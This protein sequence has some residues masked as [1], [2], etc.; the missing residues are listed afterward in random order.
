MRATLLVVVACLPAP[1][2]AQYSPTGTKVL[3]SDGKNTFYTNSPKGSVWIPNNVDPK[4]SGAR[5]YYSL[6]GGPWTF[7]ATADRARGGFEFK[8]PKEGTYN[9]AAMTVFPK[10]KTD[11]PDTSG[12]E[13]QKT[14]VYDI[15]PPTFRYV[16]T[17]ATPDG[18]PGV[19]WEATDEYLDPYKVYLEYKW[20]TMS[21]FEPIDRDKRLSPRDA[22]YWE[23]RPGERMQVHVVAYDKAG[24]MAVSDP[25]W[26]GT[27]GGSARS[28]VPLKGGIDREGR[29]PRMPDLDPAGDWPGGGSGRPAASTAVLQYI[30]DTTVKLEYRVTVG[31]AG[32]GSSKLY[33]AGDDAL[34]WKLVPEAKAVPTKP[35]VAPATL[36]KTAVE[37][38]AF[39]Y[40]VP[41]EGKYSFLIVAENA[42]GTSQPEPK[43]GDAPHATLV[44][45]ITKPAVKI[46]KTAVRSNGDRGAVLDVFWDVKDVNLPPDGIDVEYA[47][48][49]EG[50]WKSIASKVEN[51]GRYSWAVPPSE[52]AKIFVRVKATDRAGNVGEDVTKERVTIDLRKPEVEVIGVGPGAG[53]IKAGPGGPPPGGGDG[54]PPLP[55]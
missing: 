13:T 9:L 18:R 8:I 32:A 54:L 3:P 15:T 36:D 33:V 47:E 2:A 31:P 34:D 29:I 4:A 28:D 38:M 12:L 41:K 11:P 25:V 7:T 48:R 19:E 27:G 14:V 51:T 1:A 49:P 53:G 50:E 22:R 37:E 46:L 21:R 44:V 45:D 35:A 52:P 40:K 23:M 26:V 6:D 55:R 39:T 10:D 17:V 24:N 5:L 30:N 16:R 20:P 42:V 43:R